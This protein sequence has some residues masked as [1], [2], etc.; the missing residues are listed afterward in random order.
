MRESSNGLPSWPGIAFL[1]RSYL[2]PAEALAAIGRAVDLGEISV[3]AADEIVRV[4]WTVADLA[5]S[6]RPGPQECGQALAF[7]LGVA[8]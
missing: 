4:A 2:P 1:R 3:R 6:A 5:G 8:G 7:H